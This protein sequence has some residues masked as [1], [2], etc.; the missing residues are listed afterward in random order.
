MKTR[1]LGGFQVS[2]VGL[3]CNNFGIR[4]DERQTAAVVHAALDA[5]VDLFD[6]ADVYSKG[7][8][9][10][11][12]GKALGR[13]RD[14]VVIATKF[15]HEMG[16]NSGGGS[17]RW[18]RQAVEDSL[19]RL[20]TDRIDLYQIHTPDA[21]TPIDE[22][23]VTLTALIEEG[24]VLAIGCSNFNNEKIDEALDMSATKSLQA[25][26]SVQPHYNLV[27]R[28]AEEDVFPAADRHGLGVLPYFPLASGL[29][30][31]KYRK[32]TPL[33]EGA[34]LS[35]L[36]PERAERWLND[37]NFE[38]VEKLTTFATERDHSLLELSISWL[39]TRPLVVSVIAGAT[40]PEQVAQ[41]V[42]A[43][44]WE[45]S[46]DELSAIDALT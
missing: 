20:G 16:P 7:V 34:R 17:S 15:G 27:F 37:R 28:E 29:L 3:G 26:V 22:T 24:K 23:L 10:E 6:T 5:G 1:S 33:P 8:S 45:M 12:L 9:E 31:G 25:F 2:N 42:A 4:C 35:L 18:V 36:A 38:L 41:N 13:H 21:K 19:G 32:D 40:K 46:Q 39:L 43:A 11:F 44:N 30:T 14:D